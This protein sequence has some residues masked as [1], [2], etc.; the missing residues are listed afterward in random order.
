M[1]RADSYSAYQ[2]LSV[3][4]GRQFVCP[5]LAQAVR[6]C[7]VR[8]EGQ[9][10]GVGVSWLWGKEGCHW[11]SATDLGLRAASEGVL[12]SDCWTADGSLPVVTVTSASLLMEQHTG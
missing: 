8:E 11:N 5:G 10:R 9:G 6:T 2:A 4:L 12:L 3:N 7:R 1:I